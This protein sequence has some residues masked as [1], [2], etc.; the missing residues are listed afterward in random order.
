MIQKAVAGLGQN[1]EPRF[2]AV[3]DFPLPHLVNF[4]NPGPLPLATQFLHEASEV[5]VVTFHCG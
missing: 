3:G 1:L 2:M 4:S 5:G